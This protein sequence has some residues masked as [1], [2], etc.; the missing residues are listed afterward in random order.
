MMYVQIGLSEHVAA[1]GATAAH[2][3]G[4]EFS[5]Y[6]SSLILND[7]GT[8]NDGARGRPGMLEGEPTAAHLA[9]RLLPFAL[10]QPAEEAGDEEHVAAVPY[11]VE[12]LYR[13]HVPERAWEELSVGV[14]KR[15]G[16]EFKKLVD[17]QVSGGRQIV[18]GRQ[19]RVEFVGLTRQNQAQY[20]TVRV[21]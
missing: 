16:K 21:G 20:R 5:D 1:T 11:L 4:M 3:R 6:L 19:M 2:E 14:R 13:R 18:D 9:G 17:Q 15:L 8:S 10:E 7:V 12:E